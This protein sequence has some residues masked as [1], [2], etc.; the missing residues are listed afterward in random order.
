M[1]ETNLKPAQ[2][3]DI[4]NPKGSNQYSNDFGRVVL[5]KLFENPDRGDA[6]AQILA[7]KLIEEAS[8]GNVNALSLI[9]SFG[10]KK[11]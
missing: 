9:A 11:S 8:K 1:S 7:D 2:P 6:M 3:G 10:N 4:K 5:K